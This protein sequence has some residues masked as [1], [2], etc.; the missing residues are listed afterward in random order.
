MDGTTTI[1]TPV[2]GITCM[3]AGAANIAGRPAIATTG[4][5]AATGIVI[6]ARIG[7]ITATQFRIA[8]VISAATTIAT[9]AAIATATIAVIVEIAGEI[10]TTEMTASVTAQIGIW[11]VM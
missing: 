2:S 11:P 9:N 7:A 8:I 5:V 10:G 4:T 1:S 3:I 6:S